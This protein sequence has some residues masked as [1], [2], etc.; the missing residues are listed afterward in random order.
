MVERTTHASSAKCETQALLLY[1]TQHLLQIVPELDC[2]D[3]REREKMH[4]RRI[5]SK[6]LHNQQDF[7]Q[8]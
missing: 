2:T 7:Q 6:L 4:L 3:N 1:S 8:I 5:Q